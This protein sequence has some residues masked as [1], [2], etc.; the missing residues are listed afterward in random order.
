[1]HRGEGKRAAGESAVGVAVEVGARGGGGKGR[2]SGGCRWSG[3][4]EEVGDVLSASVLVDSAHQ[5]YLLVH[6]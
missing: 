3:G 1:M 4:G 6:D 5:N 2:G